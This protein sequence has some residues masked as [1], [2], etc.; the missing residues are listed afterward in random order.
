MEKYAGLRVF[1][2]GKKLLSENGEIANVPHWFVSQMPNVL[3]EGYLWSV[4]QSKTLSADVKWWAQ[5]KILAFDTPT[6]FYE[7]YENR[8]QHLGKCICLSCAL[9]LVCRHPQ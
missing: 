2:N 9:L 5:V 3:F 1:W 8:F 6:L 4:N 7:T